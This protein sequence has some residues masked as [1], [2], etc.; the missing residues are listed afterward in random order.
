PL[1][2]ACALLPNLAALTLCKPSIGMPVLLAYPPKPKRA[3]IAVG[4]AFAFLLLSVPLGW[5]TNVRSQP[6]SYIP[7]LSVPGVL[8]TLSLLRWRDPR[9]RL[10]FLTACVPQRAPYDLC[11][12]GVIP[13][14]RWQMPAWAAISWFLPVVGPYLVAFVCLFLQA[15]LP[16]SSD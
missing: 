11:A 14:S 4:A 12:L 8:L 10:L 15:R 13:S 2:A 6:D 16:A 7:L 3:W 5:L 1:M 9:A